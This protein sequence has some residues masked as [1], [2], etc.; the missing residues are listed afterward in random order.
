MN[1]KLV[2]YGNNMYKE[3]LLDDFFAGNLTI[4]T[5]KACQ[6]AFRRDRFSVGFIFR[7]D[8]KEDGQ[9]I[10]S[11]NDTVY[12]KKD[13]NIKEYVRTLAL[14]DHISICYDHSD[15]EFFCID[16]LACYDR[17]G[18]DF[19]LEI[20]CKACNEFTIG[21]DVGSTIRVDDPYLSGDMI[22]LRKAS[23]G[24]EVDFTQASVGV[25]LNGFTPR[26]DVGLLLE[27]EFLTIKGYY[28]C[29]SNGCVYTTKTAKIIT[30]QS[31]RVITY[32]N[33]NYKYPKFIKNV[34]QQFK[35]PSDEIEVLN[36]KNKDESEEQN[37]LMTVMPMLVNMLLMVGLRGIMG[38]GGMFVI[39]FAATMTVST[40]ITIINFVKDKKKRQ[41]KE[42]KRTR[43]YMEYLT[44]CEDDI[45]KLRQ[46]EEVVANFMNPT[47]DNYMKYIED[48]DN[49]LFEKR[50]NHEDYLKIRIGSGVVKSNC[51]IGY[52]QEDY[53]DT[54]D[55]LKDFPKT[56]H[57]KYEYLKDM[58]VC[59]DIKDVNAVGFVGSRTK[60]YQMEKNI[61]MEFAASHFYK[62]VKLFLIMEEEDVPLF[63]WARWLKIT[64][65]DQNKM[66][67]FMY[68]EES[69]K[70]TLEFLYSEL[71]GR[72]SLGKAPEGLPD[73]IVL[74]Y[75]SHVIRNHPVSKY[76]GK[77]K[78]LGFHFVFF[79]ECEEFLN[80]ECS[81]RIFLNDSDYMGYIQNAEDGEKI[82][83]FEYGHISR[84][85][86]EEAAKKLACVYVDEVSLEN[87]LTKNITL[88]RLLNIMNPYDLELEARWNNSQI[89]K[90]MAAP[91][92]VKSGNEIVY[93]DLHEKFHGPHGLVAGTTGSGKSEI[94]QTYILSMAT[95][96]HP[97][98]VGFIIIDFKGGGMVNQFKELPH[99]NGAITNIDGNEIERSL[100]SIKAELLK[101]QELFAAH[102]VNH[103]DDYIRE[104]KAGKA[105]TPLPHLILI[106][107]EFAELKSEQP[108]FM[109]EL[110][111]TARIGR[112]LGV[113]LILATQKPSGVVS[114]QIW[115]NSK[116][117]LCL[118]VQNKSDSNE[119]LKS[120][121][122]AEI[123]EPG[124]AYL[125]VGN[126]EIF[127]LFQSAYSGASANN[128]GITAQKKFMITNVELSGKRRIIYEQKPSVDDG[129]ET[130][131]K[132]LVSYINE[133]CEKKN[134]KR[135]PDICLP[136]LPDNVPITM[137]GFT[138]EGT[139]V[140][141]P[142]GI[143]DD[144]AR[145]N[146]YIETFNLSQNNVYILGS[147]QSGKT[148][149][150]QTI[151]RGLTERYSPKEV[152]IYLLDFA[153]MILRNF[154]PL[155]HV[156]GVIT[157]SDEERLK[158]FLK[159][160]YETIQKRKQFFSKLGLSSY[161]AYRES[162]KTELPQIVVCLDNWV[163]FRGHFPDYEDAFV[164][165][166]RDSISV[167]I[168]IIVTAGQAGGAGFKLL[169]SFSKRTALYCNDSSD[170]G[171]LFES[172]RKKINDIAG[173]GIIENNK[174][175]YECQYYLAF[176]AE[177]EFEKL[178]LIRQFIG[179]IN[180]K[181]G[182][183][184]VAGIPEI[185]ERVTE[186]FLMKQYG[187]TA[188]APYEIPL[189]MEFDSI[190]LRTLKLDSV[191]MLT[192]MG[193]AETGKHAYIEYVI[194]NILSRNISEPA[195]V[196]IVDN[197]ENEYKK[198]E[199]AAT[200]Y[201]DSAEG[202]RQILETVAQKLK[203]REAVLGAEAMD[204][205][206]EA[207]QLVVINSASHVKALGTDKELLEIYKY[208]CTCKKQKICF[209]ITDIENVMISLSAGEVLKNIK[210]SRRVIAFEDIKKIKAVDVSISDTK[211]FKK[212]LEYNDAYLFEGDKIEK[213]RT[214]SVPP[215]N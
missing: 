202:M 75:K 165:M 203:Q 206:R 28:F 162:G 121:L 166:C 194:D 122:A 1:Y 79:E 148:N 145:Q 120:P 183:V 147:S 7:I 115:S 197:M 4:G 151:I 205:S 146:Q 70:V 68:D 160:M 177:K 45:I 131:L 81:S 152:N 189:G 24:Y 87:T 143:I 77:A 56:M 182:D 158:G 48:F 111:S 106:V 69:A 55:E 91:I 66:R 142:V 125:Q 19:D 21:G 210:E 184:Y 59:M 178:K 109:K 201:A 213:I 119:V 169:S 16:F 52:K 63:D 154:E 196:Y 192:F 200:G 164:N 188:G 67:N 23:A 132:A 185:P 124:R 49:R 104:Y 190:T 54:D 41:E 5:D 38:G 2:I 161:S 211:K 37:F 174:M 95:L 167:G 110:I 191:F 209:L 117:K 15:V 102:E 137:E 53:V 171:V 84:K 118:K 198:Y 176:A 181:Y 156:A 44:K 78:E 47:L 17:V 114:D 9:F 127:Q 73:Y 80:S 107:D 65:N 204:I 199:A 83:T 31:K 140:V 85:N 60:L 130:Q 26:E 96:F 208:I 212:P 128:D 89:Y 43:V 134:I 61:I 101:R 195:D 138:Y 173:R 129:G 168:S 144:P 112:S 149:L 34:R 105:K 214:V 42:E 135:L 139:D 113:H 186:E 25:E 170:Y 116:F 33:N 159:L 35:V 50:R 99:L 76:I 94:L 172:C 10:I 163:A 82:Q 179:D 71:S 193:N 46:R 40:T 74:V 29:I 136:S 72:E 97:Y 64:Y 14:G 6:V 150:L 30:N 141:I 11:C 8:R 58:P 207:L 180:K 175:F 18:D 57:D 157:P 108:E 88:F 3:I 86:A 20:D 27:G 51:Q 187:R 133:Y 13:S 22:S 100:L 62:D 155:N 36:P 126:N 32:Q 103:I 92:G 123:K 93:L 12:L 153:S 215:Q 90:S 98:E 39:Y